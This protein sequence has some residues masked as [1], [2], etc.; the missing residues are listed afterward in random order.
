MI[1]ARDYELRAAELH[2]R[3]FRVLM[4]CIYAAAVAYAL[5]SAWRLLGAFTAAIGG[6]LR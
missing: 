3:L 6:A 2:G 4:G 1:P 5:D